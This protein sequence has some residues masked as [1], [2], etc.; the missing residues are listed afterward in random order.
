MDI[1][2]FYDRVDEL[3]KKWEISGEVDFAKRLREAKVS[4]S[5][6]GEILGEIGLVLKDFQQSQSDEKASDLEVKRL[7]EFVKEALG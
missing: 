2:K 7:S 1:W 6:S 4:G 5:T 3:A